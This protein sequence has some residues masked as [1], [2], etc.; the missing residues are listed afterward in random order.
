[1]FGFILKL[2]LSAKQASSHHQLQKTAEGRVPSAV[3][4]TCFTDEEHFA[5]FRQKKSGVLVLAHMHVDLR[6]G[7]FYSILVKCLLDLLHKIKM[8]R[9]IIGGFAP[10]TGDKFHAA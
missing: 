2:R 10:N 5:V 7:D 6:E 9:P 8:H 3:F 1:M 4:S